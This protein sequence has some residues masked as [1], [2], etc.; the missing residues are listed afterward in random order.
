METLHGD[1]LRYI[2]PYFQL[3][4]LELGCQQVTN[5]LAL[6]TIIFILFVH[7]KS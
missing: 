2:T 1:V 7:Y 6:F 3:G 5:I 4:M